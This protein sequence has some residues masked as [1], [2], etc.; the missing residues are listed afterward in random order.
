MVLTHTVPHVSLLQKGVYP[1]RLVE[2]GFYGSSL[3]GLLPA[4]DARKKIALWVFGH[5]H[6]G[7][8]ATIEHVNY[9]SHPRRVHRGLG[10]VLCFFIF[11]DFDWD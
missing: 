2:A 3:M 7:A 9:Q 6:A 1:K 11:S 4:V 10:V 5:S 8:D